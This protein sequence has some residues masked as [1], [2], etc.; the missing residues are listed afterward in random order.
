MAHE[1]V[2]EDG[3]ITHP[4]GTGPFEFVEWKPNDYIRLKKFK[5]Y[6]M[7]GLPY[8]DELILKP[9]PDETIRLTSL[10]TGDLDIARF[11]PLDEVAKYKENPQPGYVLEICPGGAIWDIGFNVSKPP[12]DDKRV[13]QAFA[14][15]IDKNEIELGISFGVGQVVNQP[16]FRE[17]FW[18]CDVP[19]YERDVEKAKALLKEAGYPDGLDITLTTANSYPQMLNQAAIM[20]AQLK[21]AGFNVEL[22]V[23]DWV[24]LVSK[25][26]TGEYTVQSGG[27]VATVDPST[28]YPWIFVP[29]ATFNNL[30][31]DAYDNP[32]VTRLIN[33]GG[34][35]IDPDERKA[36]YTEMLKILLDDCPMIF[37]VYTGV[38]MGWQSRVK[39]Y[40]STMTVLVYSGGGLQYTWLD[41]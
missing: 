29:G 24:T 7:E 16:F 15:G 3:S 6:W 26:R 17:N 18:Y 10:K 32:E 20:Q 39:D 21:E 2:N 14:Y 36:I 4:I 11:L 34:Q 33:K 22:D 19:D 37:T 28:V 25:Y 35:T 5:D 8:L 31:G 12:F 27:W 13:R 40:D 9:V 30:I 38:G 1:S 23:S 41:K